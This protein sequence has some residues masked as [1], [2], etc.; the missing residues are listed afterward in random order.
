MNPAV[1]LAANVMFLC[2]ALLCRNFVTSSLNLEVTDLVWL[3]R[4]EKKKKS[5]P[6]IFFFSTDLI[7]SLV[8]HADIGECFLRLVGKEC[9]VSESI[10]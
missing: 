1:L 5:I 2:L 10:C 8:G 9:E 4:G 6:S 7:V 3:L